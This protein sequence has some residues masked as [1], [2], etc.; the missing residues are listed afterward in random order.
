[1]DYCHVHSPRTRSGQRKAGL[2]AAALKKKAKSG[3]LKGATDLI[4][5][6]SPPQTLNDII[7]VLAGTTLG[8]LRGEMSAQ[9]AHAVAALMKTMFVVLKESNQLLP[10]LERMTN[11]ELLQEM[12]LIAHN[13]KIK[14]DIVDVVD[15]VD[16]DEDSQDGSDG[17]QPDSEQLGGVTGKESS[18]QPDAE[19]VVQVCA[20]EP[21]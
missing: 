8:V 15:A 20:K 17:L 12:E 14:R 16:P 18:V 5:L 7:K 13:I 19:G 21:S 3:E 10:N 1:V 11:E 9:G 2:R 4:K 6:E